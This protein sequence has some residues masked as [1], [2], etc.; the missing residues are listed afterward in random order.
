MSG[1]PWNWIAIILVSTSASMF[2]LE[3][4]FIRQILQRIEKNSDF[5]LFD[6]KQVLQ[7]IE[8]KLDK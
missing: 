6:I 3:L 8:K 4:H 2:V 1:H 5:L 7:R